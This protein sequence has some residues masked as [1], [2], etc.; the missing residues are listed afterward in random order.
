MDSKARLDILSV[1]LIENYIT[2]RP[3]LTAVRKAEGSCIVVTHAKAINITS[4]DQ[5]RASFDCIMH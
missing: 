2:L 4:T 3:G 5:E 1:N